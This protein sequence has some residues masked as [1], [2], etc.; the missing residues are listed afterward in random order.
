MGALQSY[1]QFPFLILHPKWLLHYWF[2]VNDLRC[3][4]HMPFRDVAVKLAHLKIGQREN[5]EIVQV[6]GF[7]INSELLQ[8][9]IAC[10]GG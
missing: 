9:L 2:R 6:Y 5:S 1:C 3:V 8:I 4:V 7:A 10:N